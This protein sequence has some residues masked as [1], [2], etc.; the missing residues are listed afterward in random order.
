MEKAGGIYV[1]I[2]ILYGENHASIRSLEKMGYKN[3]FIFG[4]PG[5]IREEL[6]H[7]NILI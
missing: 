6:S 5:K 2:G 4:T 1:L 7:C 3:M